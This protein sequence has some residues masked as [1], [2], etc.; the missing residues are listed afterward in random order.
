MSSMYKAAPLA[1]TPSQHH[2]TASYI[3]FHRL[4][5]ACFIDFIAACSLDRRATNL[6]PCIETTSMTTTSDLIVQ[7]R[8]DNVNFHVEGK[9]YI[10]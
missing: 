8:V 2:Q 9:Q 1:G 10:P 7:M 3:G 6:L 5:R 4:Q